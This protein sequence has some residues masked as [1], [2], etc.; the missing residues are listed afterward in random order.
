MVHDA[1]SSVGWYHGGRYNGSF[2]FF[3]EFTSE[4][5]GRAYIYVKEL[6]TRA[7]VMALAAA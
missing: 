2:T 7:T 4:G 5:R 6:L 3:A 1:T